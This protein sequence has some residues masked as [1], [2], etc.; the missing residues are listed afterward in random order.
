MQYVKVRNIL[1]QSYANGL[2]PLCHTH[3]L[4]A[5]FQGHTHSLEGNVSRSEQRLEDS[6][7]S[8][9]YSLEGIM[10]RPSTQFKS[11]GHI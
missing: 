9:R 7:S 8:H 11:Q 5:A 4:E 2:G 1:S 6:M 10:P 3:S